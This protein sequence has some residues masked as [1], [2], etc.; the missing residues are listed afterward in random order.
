MPPFLS[1]LLSV[2]LCVYVSMCLCLC[3]SVCVC[4][5]LCVSVCVC[6]CVS[7]S[8]CVCVCEFVCLCVSVCLCV[9]LFVCL[10]GWLATCVYL[11]TLIFDSNYLFCLPPRLPLPFPLLVSFFFRFHHHPLFT[12]IAPVPPPPLSFLSL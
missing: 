10:S 9:C 12:P 11:S 3:V 8:V 7:V 2:C 1:L 5:C 4:V 6:L